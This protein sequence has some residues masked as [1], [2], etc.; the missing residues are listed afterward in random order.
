[1]RECATDFSLVF[2]NSLY[3]F[4]W[5]LFYTEFVATQFV[6]LIL[7]LSLRLSL[8]VPSSGEASIR[9]TATHAIVHVNKSYCIIIQTLQQ[10]QKLTENQ[11]KCRWLTS[12]LWAINPSKWV[13]YL[14]GYPIVERKPINYQNSKLSYRPV[15]VRRDLFNDKFEREIKVDSSSWFG[16]HKLI[17][18][19]MAIYNVRYWK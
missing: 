11:T 1:M 10:E 8:V 19:Q 3:L 6:F 2:L 4:S 18:Y 17:L 5:M 9:I 7:W 12:L 16:F 13:I 15:R 14:H